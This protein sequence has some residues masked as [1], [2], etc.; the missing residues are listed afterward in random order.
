MSN[1]PSSGLLML[2]R[3]LLFWLVLC[4][5]AAQAGGALAQMESASAQS[6][7]QAGLPMCPDPGYCFSSPDARNAWA[8]ENNC[9]FNDPKCEDTEIKPEG[10]VATAKAMGRF[11]EGLIDGLK[12]QLVDLWE[13]FKELFTNPSEVWEG[14]KA[15]GKLIIEDP[16]AALELFLDL[17]GED[18]AKLLKCGAYD[19]GKV[20]GKYVSPFFVLKVAKIIAKGGK[21]ADAV[22]KVR[23][24]ILTPAEKLRLGIHY[25]PG[26]KQP[27]GKSWF[28]ELDI[29]KR[30]VGIEKALGN[31]TPDAFPVIDIFNK[32][33]GEVTSIKSKSP[34]S[35]FW[36]KPGGLLDSLKADIRALADFVEDGIDVVKAWE[37][38]TPNAGSDMVVAADKV[39]TKTLLVAVKKDT[40]TEGHYAEIRQAQEYANQLVQSGRSTRPIKIVIVEID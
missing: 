35:A 32:A 8:A 39:K 27:N 11:V 38:G 10:V 14:L 12:Q 29:K 18:V 21:L 33:T 40:L 15:L 5:L 30:G 36:S 24:M 22:K 23:D 6:P 9:T 17:L 25:I 16:K 34:S 20:I 3:L 26:I 1:D 4:I 19:Q 31:N 13:F 7:S 28:D 2:K 37:K